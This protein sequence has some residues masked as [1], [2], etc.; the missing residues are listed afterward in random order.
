MPAVSFG[1][2]RNIGTKSLNQ[3][4]NFSVRYDISQSM[5]LKFQ[6]TTVTKDDVGPFVVPENSKDRVTAYAVGLDF[7]F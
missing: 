7:V 6:T 4:F 1:E 3:E 2:I 5:A